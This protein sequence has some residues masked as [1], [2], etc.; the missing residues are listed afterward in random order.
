M[1]SDTTEER[2]NIRILTIEDE[3]LLREYVCDYLED[4]GFVTLQAD[5]GRLGLELI[6]S[7]VPDLV[8]TDLRMPEMNGLDVLAAMQKEFPEIPV[9]VISGTGTLNDVVQT[10]KLG[11]WDYILKPI[12]DYSIL[13]LSVKRV[14]E[15]KR[16]FEENKRYRQHLEEEVAIRTQD[17]L[18]STLK[19]KTLF[20][21][22]ADAIIIHDQ[23]GN[24]IDIN[25][26]AIQYLDCEREQIL[27][28]TIFELFTETE[29]DVLSKYLADLNQGKH[30][31]FESSLKSGA[32][33]VI[34]VEVSASLVTM[35][36]TPQILAVARNITERKKAEEDRRELEKQIVAAQKMEILG[37]LASGVAHDFNNILSALTGYTVLLRSKMQQGSA[38]VEYLEKINGIIAMGQ[39]IARRITT[40]V[41][42]GKDELKVVDMH[43]VLCDTEAMLLPNCRK[44]NVELHLQAADYHI[45]GDEAQLQNAFLNLGINARDAMPD[46][47]SLLF[48]TANITSSENGEEIKEICIEVR[49]TGIGMDRQTMARIFDPLF[50]T[51]DGAKGTGL[52]LT[53]VLYCVK[54]LHGKIDVQSTPGKGTSFQIRFPLHGDLSNRE[55]VHNCTGKK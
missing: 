27:K 55:T 54:N 49:D 44:I 53:S 47:G 22:A 12:H 5:N 13:E 19:F 41:K 29:K 36:G 51:K 33:A 46:G 26:K 31:L 6:R 25:Q 32:S 40:F 16:L 48:T 43:K 21:L 15:R 34:P 18:K 10:L 7:E 30:I 20:N 24:I 4:I 11:A 28:L 39:N 45:M 9:V 52:G 50:T 14:L 37:L 17:L 8:L 2:K 1:L 42:K 35:D 38:E 23:Q 3:D